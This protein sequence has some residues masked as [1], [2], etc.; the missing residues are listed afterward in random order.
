MMRGY[1][2]GYENIKDENA[3]FGFRWDVWFGTKED[4]MTWKTREEAERACGWFENRAI[5]LRLVDGGTHICK[6]F[7]VEERKPGQFVIYCDAPF[8]PSQVW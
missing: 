5:K 1:V 2:K 6:G 7:K 4:G 8:D 3:P